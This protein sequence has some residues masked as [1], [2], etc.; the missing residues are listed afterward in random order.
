MK[1][2]TAAAASSFVNE[3]Q[4]T[5]TQAPL[6]GSATSIVLFFSET[7]MCLACCRVT[8]QWRGL[9][10]GGGGFEGTLNQRNYS[11]LKQCEI[12][13]ASI[14]LWTR[15]KNL[16]EFKKRYMYIQCH[17]YIK[18]YSYKTSAP[19][20]DRRIAKLTL[21]LNIGHRQDFGSGVFATVFK[22]RPILILGKT[23]MKMKKATI[24]Y[25]KSS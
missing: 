6:P 15:S 8:L 4:P 18:S 21:I 9:G 25:Q 2:F 1:I 14:N 12:Y 13:G 3:T 17:T 23:V 16:W 24:S 10:G 22:F 20:I 19:R 7:T 11:L 5:H